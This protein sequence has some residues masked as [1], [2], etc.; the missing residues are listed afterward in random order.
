MQLNSIDLPHE[1]SVGNGKMKDVAERGQEPT[2][3]HSPLQKKLETRNS[4]S[5]IY[6][7]EAMPF[8]IVGKSPDIVGNPG[9]LS[10]RAT[11]KEKEARAK[12]LLWSEERCSRSIHCSENVGS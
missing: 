4:Q 11:D 5:T 6:E 10:S 2:P 9:G 8:G 7:T 12:G 1:S 3:K